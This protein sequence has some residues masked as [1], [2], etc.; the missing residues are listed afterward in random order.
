[1]LKH[2]KMYD[3]IF[4]HEFC[5][6][7]LQF[8]KYAA[9]FDHLSRKYQKL[10]KYLHCRCRV[11]SVHVSRLFNILTYY[12][13]K[14]TFSNLIWVIYILI[15][16]RYESRRLVIF[17]YIGLKSRKFLFVLNIKVLIHIYIYIYIIQY[18]LHSFLNWYRLNEENSIFLLISKCVVTGNERNMKY[19]TE[20]TNRI[21]T[22]HKFI[23]SPKLTYLKYF[24]LSLFTFIL[25]SYRLTM[26]FFC[27]LPRS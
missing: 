10:F 2:Y 3:V 1:M 13:A 8:K 4:F 9:I 12:K 24:Q 5:F 27:F 17:S 26:L 16:N 11:N 7:Q 18:I 14:L 6:T 21:M 15:A 23:I 19:A 20:T 25:S 22:S